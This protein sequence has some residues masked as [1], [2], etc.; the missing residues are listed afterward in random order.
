MLAFSK[1]KKKKM[2]SA[3]VSWNVSEDFD[4]KILNNLNMLTENLAL[5][6]IATKFKVEKICEG[7]C[8]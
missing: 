1:S 5:N 8:I 2:I 6:F 4:A 7:H 3:V